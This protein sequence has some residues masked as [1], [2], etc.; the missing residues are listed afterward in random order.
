LTRSAAAIA[1]PSMT[2]ALMTASLAHTGD[3]LQRSAQPSAR[4]SM[5]STVA[6]MA[7]DQ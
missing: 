5:P 2:F 1:L 7:S 6:A 4:G 3:L